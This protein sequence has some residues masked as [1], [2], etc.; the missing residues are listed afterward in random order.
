MLLDT[1]RI[2]LFNEYLYNR[3]NCLFRFNLIIF[4]NFVVGFCVAKGLPHTRVSGTVCKQQRVAILTDET[5]SP[6]DEKTRM[7]GL[8]NNISVK[9]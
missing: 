5:F 9:R 4:P 7:I 3:Q 6:L 1:F 2:F 8:I